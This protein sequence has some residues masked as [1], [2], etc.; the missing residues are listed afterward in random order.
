MLITYDNLR[1]KGACPEGLGWF[2]K[3]FGGEVDHN[4]LIVALAIEG[5]YEW[6]KWFMRQWNCPKLNKEANFAIAKAYFH[7][8]N[9]FDANTQWLAQ[10]ILENEA[11]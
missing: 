11:N 5:R 2:R 8:V 7:G 10:L 9:T 4:V 3:R 1:E 6:S